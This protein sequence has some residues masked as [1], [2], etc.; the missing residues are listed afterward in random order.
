MRN[1]QPVEA[2]YWKTKRHTDRATVYFVVNMRIVLIRTTAVRGAGIQGTGCCC[3]QISMIRCVIDQLLLETLAIL[4]QSH[5]IGR[6]KKLL[7]ERMAREKKKL[8]KVTENI[9]D[10][11]LVLVKSPKVTCFPVYLR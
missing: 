7:D 2:E 8:T 4:Y 10:P 6:T 11:V 1:I 9:L 3:I 5:D